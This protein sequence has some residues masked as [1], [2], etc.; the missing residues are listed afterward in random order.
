VTTYLGHTSVST[1][2]WLDGGAFNVQAFGA[3]G[4]G[5]TDD[6]V[7]IQA[8]ITAAMAVGTGGGTVTFPGGRDYRITAALTVTGACTLMSTD[9]KARL[10]MDTVDTPAFSVSASNVQFVGLSIRG[11]QSASFTD[12]ETA[13]RILGTSAASPVTNVEVRECT[14]SRWGAY[15]IYA[16]W[17]TDFAFCDNVMS[18]IAY[19]GI[20][21]LSALRG[22]ISRNQITDIA[23]GTSGNAYGISLTRRG[24]QT[25]LVTYP[26]SADIVVSDNVVRD[27]P[28]WHGYDTHAGQR[29][30]F[31]GNIAYNCKRGIA[32]GSATDSAGDYTIAPLDVSVVNNIL[33][34][35][36]SDGTA[37]EGITFSGTSDGGAAGAQVEYATGVVSGNVVRG[38][39]DKTNDSSGA[40][41]TYTTR[42]LV[43]ANN[44][45]IE[46]SPFGVM[47]YQDNDGFALSGNVAVDPWSNTVTNAAL[48]NLR[49]SYNYGTAAGN[50][51]ARGSKSA[52][53]FCVRGIS[54]EAQTGN[55]V[56]FGAN[57]FVMAEGNAI[58]A[59]AGRAQF[60]A[61]SGW[62][63]DVGN[64]GATLTWG[65][66]PE[67]QL[68]ST[69]L[70]ADRTV[71][72]AT[73][74]TVGGI[75][76]IGAQFH[77]RR[78]GAGAFNLIVN[79]V[80]IVQNEW[81]TCRWN[82]SAWVTYAKG[83]LV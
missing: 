7:A 52:T 49:V 76:P 61:A 4:D 20:M 5:S 29:C 82:G 58:V 31:S 39:G 42:G 19:G 44:T 9:G 63:S 72:L 6:T 60:I 41:S 36:L 64:A 55:R 12:D 71:T 80:N 56:T 48:A 30:V 26:R 13:I 79:G 40:I 43:I 28:L 38:Y 50:T 70:T 37:A 47:L 1:L 81:I 62:G 33:D 8:A 17:L 23:P 53:Y 68:W 11:K 27:V 25:S 3:V 14:F 57:D 54:V 59:D 16:E 75:P 18:D 34:S 66:D 15:G 73:T 65:T 74:T 77:C 10:V 2:A 32:V 21:V 24:D 83:P 35:G 67:N 69:A 45:I 78:T 22:T 46:P 51:L